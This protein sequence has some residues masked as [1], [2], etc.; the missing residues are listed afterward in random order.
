[1]NNEIIKKTKK[2]V[3][4]NDFLGKYNLIIN[5]WNAPK[6]IFNSKNSCVIYYSMNLI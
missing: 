6:K 2:I 1:M 5:T 4:N 3:I